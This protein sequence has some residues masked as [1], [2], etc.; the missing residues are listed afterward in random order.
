MRFKEVVSV[1]RIFDE[2]TGKE[3][4]GLIEDDL[5]DV[6]NRIA[7][8]HREFMDLLKKYDIKDVKT[9]ELMLF[10]RKVW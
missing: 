5:L 9:L 4:Y 6:I 3:Y 2:E 1:E 8:E 7:D 10:H